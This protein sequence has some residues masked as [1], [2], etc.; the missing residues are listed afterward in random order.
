MQAPPARLG[1][2]EFQTLSRIRWDH[3]IRRRTIASKDLISPQLGNQN[4]AKQDEIKTMKLYHLFGSHRAST[5]RVGLHRQRHPSETGTIGEAGLTTLFRR[6]TCWSYR[7]ATRCGAS[8]EKGAGYR[9][10]VWRDS[11]IAGTSKRLQSK[12]LTRRCGL[13]DQV[14]HLNGDFLELPV[15]HNE[16]DVVVGLLC[17]LHIGHWRQL[18]TRYFDSLKPG[19]LL[20]VDDIFPSWRQVDRRRSTH[21]ETGH[22]LHETPEFEDATTKW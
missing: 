11:L 17:F 15:Q 14:T 1:P 8:R 10:G 16:C 3:S 9:H 19:G 4:M 2:F 7:Q 18:F 12:D 20:Y 5:E 13:D 21:A 22:L 6:R